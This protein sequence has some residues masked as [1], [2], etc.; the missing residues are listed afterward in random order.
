MSST[1]SKSL[2]I[3][4]IFIEKCSGI[5]GTRQT[6]SHVHVENT[7]TLPAESE[8]HPCDE[9]WVLYTMDELLNTISKTNDV[10]LY[11]GWMNLRKKEKYL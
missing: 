6:Y 7:P 5:Q 3:Q 8:R 2:I 11:V 10:L 4:C 1:L 9:N